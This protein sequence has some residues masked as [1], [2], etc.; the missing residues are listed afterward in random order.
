[1]ISKIFQGDCID[2]LQQMEYVSLMVADPPDNIG[3][4]YNDY[5]D[6]RHDYYDWL[7]YVV[8]L[9]LD[10]TDCLFLSYYWK[11]DL[12]IKHNS[13]K[14]LKKRPHITA[15]TFIWRYTFGQH[16]SHDFGSGFRYLLRFTKP[17]AKF[18]PDSIRVVSKRQKLGDLRANPAGRVPDD[19]WDFP[20]VV[21]NS[22]ERRKWHP[23]QHP[24]A[25]IRR[26]ILMHSDPNDLVVDLFAGTGTVLRVALAEGRR[27][28][29]AEI[30]FE[31]CKR[32]AEENNV[33]IVEKL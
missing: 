32:I 29:V 1:M 21:G 4:K 22:S 28:L 20:R 31:Y 7:D 15:K 8:Q 11:H 19:V 3:L 23:T 33:L 26:I 27:A 24:E 13:Y 12:R 18:N 25:L 17:S 5:V 10:K 16:N 2:M 30:D 9:A 14:L 6:K